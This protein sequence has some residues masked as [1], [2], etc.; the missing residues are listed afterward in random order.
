ME[1]PLIDS[2]V[3]ALE[4]TEGLNAL[5]VEELRL[6]AKVLKTSLA[7]ARKSKGF[8]VWQEIHKEFKERAETENLKG[9]D[10]KDMTLDERT[11]VFEKAGL[12]TKPRADRQQ[13]TQ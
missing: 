10:L 6:R 12:I 11:K 1:K 3:E 7:E 8:K 2:Y 4:A 5:E 9:K 13:A